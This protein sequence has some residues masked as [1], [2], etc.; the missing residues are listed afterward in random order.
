MTGEIVS[1]GIGIN[2][3]KRKR[4][5]FLF[6]RIDQTFFWPAKMIIFLMSRVQC[7][8]FSSNNF[9]HVSGHTLLARERAYSFDD[10]HTDSADSRKNAEKNNR[11]DIPESHARRGL[12]RKRKIGIM[13][14]KFPFT[15]RRC[16]YFIDNTERLAYGKSIN[17]Y[18]GSIVYIRHLLYYVSL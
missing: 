17:S 10:D 14:N 6:P 11:N 12:D 3:Y 8:C 4:S 1:G 13:I 9:S 16:L 18:N 7:G 15:S 2:D 5:R